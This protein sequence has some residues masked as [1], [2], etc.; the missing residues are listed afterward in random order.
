MNFLVVDGVLVRQTGTR[1]N[2]MG[3][4]ITKSVHDVFFGHPDTIWDN[5]PYSLVFDPPRDYP[6]VLTR[7][8]NGTEAQESDD[9]QARQTDWLF[10]VRALDCLLPF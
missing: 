1:A 5:T 2:G 10:S 9:L 6:G 4:F 7:Q 3:P 8:E